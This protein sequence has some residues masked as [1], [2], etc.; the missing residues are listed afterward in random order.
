MAHVDRHYRRL[1]HSS[2]LLSDINLIF[3]G[4]MSVKNFFYSFVTP[5]C[6][7]FNTKTLRTSAIM[8]LS[9]LY[10]NSRLNIF[11]RRAFVQLQKVCAF[12][13][14]EIRNSGG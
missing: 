10:M 13:K 11:F 7:F 3:N 9:E 6:E 4:Q 5:L 14:G 8:N 2:T 12:L 1:H